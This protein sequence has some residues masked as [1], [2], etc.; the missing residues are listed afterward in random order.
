MGVVLS[1]DRF[2]GDGKAIAVLVDDEGRT[3]QMPRAFL[4]EGTK[5]GEVVRLALERDPEATAKLKA[6]VAALQDELSGSDPGG[7]VDL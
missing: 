3:V 4:P 2:E 6:D 7:D 1:V 5:A